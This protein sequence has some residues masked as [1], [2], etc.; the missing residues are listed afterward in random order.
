[1]TE[2]LH[3][4]WHL[5][6]WQV[7]NAQG[8]SFSPYGDAPR[9]IL[10]YATDGTMYAFLHHPDWPRTTEDPLHPLS[11][12]YSGRW[13]WSAGLVR[14][15]VRFSS[16]SATIG[17]T[18]VRHCAFDGNMGLILTTDPEDW[19]GVGPIVHRLAWSRQEPTR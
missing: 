8:D 10:H 6:A 12:A 14:H 16:L 3:G 1:M 9:G 11:T 4:S 19:S 18:L 17:Q 13:T 2:R 15:E 5:L 7:R